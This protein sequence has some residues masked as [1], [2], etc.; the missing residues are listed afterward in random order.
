MPDA[1]RFDKYGSFEDIQ[2]LLEHALS[3]TEARSISDISRF[4][5]EKSV[6][7]ASSLSATLA[8]LEYVSLVESS[9]G[10]FIR[11][12]E[13][14][15][16]RLP[17]EMVDKIFSRLIDEGSLS[18]FILPEA[19]EYDPVGNTICLRNN[20]VPLEYS[21]LKNLLISLDF[22]KPHPLS[23]NLLQITKEL[24][25]LFETKL[26]PGIKEEL[27]PEARLKGLS[28]TALMRM[29]EL[30][31][32]HGRE[33]EEFVLNYERRR[34]GGS[35]AEKVRIISDLQCDAGYDIVSFEAVSSVQPD[36]FIEVKSFSGEPS[37]FW[38]RNEIAVSDARKNQYFLCL[39][40]RNLMVQEDYAPLI[41]QNPH[42]NIFLN[43]KEW[44]R[45]TMS[46]FFHK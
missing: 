34:L 31:E 16:A 44:E 28:L 36:R 1:L 19:I 38:S 22:F 12:R 8:L 32:L 14:D 18:V 13:Y 41:I 20:L 11:S 29:Q 7:L 24:E 9:K 39:V 3:A 26:I 25:T 4:C 33:A 15:N 45:D 6:M 46:W 21:G 35:T 17:R 37:F 23:G 40:N 42:E 10:S 5:E 43:N 2:F 30:N 27:F